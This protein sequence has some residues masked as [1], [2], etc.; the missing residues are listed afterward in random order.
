MRGWQVR[1]TWTC[2][3]EP[4]SSKRAIRRRS[5]AGKVRHDSPQAALGSLMGLHRRKGWQ[6]Q[7][8][9]YQCR[10]CGGY[11]FGHKAR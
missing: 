9:V 7:M 5:C 6:G 1:R 8:N 11:H 10:F 2:D 4:M 3:S